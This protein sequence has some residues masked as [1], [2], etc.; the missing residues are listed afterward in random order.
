M[1]S[2]TNLSEEYN[3][4]VEI[5][6]RALRLVV[7]ASKVESKIVHSKA[8]KVNVFDYVE[9]VIINDKLTFINESGL[10]YSLYA[11]CTIEDLIDI[12]TKL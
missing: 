12:L 7:N 9:L 10:Q 3:A 8:L 11:D 1:G 2:Y 5:I 6:E 4:L